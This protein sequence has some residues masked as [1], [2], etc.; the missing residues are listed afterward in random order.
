MV[1]NAQYK[2]HINFRKRILLHL[3]VKTG[4]IF[5]LCRMNTVS[6][7]YTLEN[8]C[9]ALS[10]SHLTYQ[11]IFFS[12]II[13]IVNLITLKEFKPMKPQA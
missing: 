1:S 3:K 6:P 8:K 5:I 13:H 2:F 9:Y 4:I 7:I 11:D 10:W 12:T